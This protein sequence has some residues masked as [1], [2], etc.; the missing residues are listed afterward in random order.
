MSRTQTPG[1]PVTIGLDVG[2]TKT[3]AVAFDARRAKVA[4]ITRPTETGNP[5]TV[6][7]SIVATVD[8]LIAQ[9]GDRPVRA[10]G[11]GVPGL[12]DNSNGLVRQAVNLGIGNEPLDLA[13][14]LRDRFGVECHV[15]NDVNAAALGSH[16]LLGEVGPVVDLAYLSI[17]TG[18][19]AGIVLGG[20]V[21]RGKRGV[22]GEIGHLPVRQD[23]PMCH[24]GLSGC[25]EAIASGS[26][27]ARQWQTPDGSGSVTSLIDAAADRNPVAVFIVDRFADALAHAVYLLS[28][29]FDVDRIVIGGGVADVGEPLLDLVGDGVRRLEKR[30]SFVASLALPS[31]LLLT[32]CDDV[33]AR[34]AAA[35]VDQ[36]ADGGGR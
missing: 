20:R 31:R 10:I 34:G 18:I 12:V 1:E 17:G 32:S 25:L 2:G 27:I 23:G 8:A 35:L 24:C 28:V 3:H 36:P 14:T 21:H 9:I 15:D 33:A 29:T 16:R 19:A 30:S 13:G 7:A 11:V 5:S 4:D 6:G 26:A 22:A